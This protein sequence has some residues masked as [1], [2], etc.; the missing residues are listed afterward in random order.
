MSKGTSEPSTP[1][2][3]VALKDRFESEAA[4]VKDRQGWENLRIQWMGRKKGIVR[5]LMPHIRHV[6]PKDR[7]AFGQGVNQ[8]KT[9]VES[10]LESLDTELTDQETVRE[11]PSI[12]VTLPGRRP[13]LGTEHP[14]T[15]VMAEIEMI[16]AEMGYRVAEGPEIESDFHNFEALEYSRKSSGSR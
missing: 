6:E 15:R 8:L 11:T 10:S 12:D 16:F 1:P 9:L 4:A 7:K 14:V 2:D 5:S 13:E 3:L